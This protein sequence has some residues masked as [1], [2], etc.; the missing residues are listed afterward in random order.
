MGMFDEFILKKPYTCEKCKEEIKTVQT[1]HFECTLENYSIGDVIKSY[2]PNTSKEITGVFNE[3][4]Y[5]SKCKIEKQIFIV[6]KRNIYIGTSKTLKKAQ[7]KLKQFD[8]EQLLQMYKKENQK[9]EQIQNMFSELSSLIVEFESYNKRK[10]KNK[11]D[12]FF[13]RN[14]KGMKNEDFV[15]QLEK[16]NAVKMQE[17]QELKGL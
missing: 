10:G 12:D 13:Y 15:K 11:M 7:K 3:T 14:V 5:C 2:V 16:I 8:Y 9:K 6:V 1:K 17:L 4:I